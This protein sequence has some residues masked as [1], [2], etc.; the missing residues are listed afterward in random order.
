[1]AMLN[2]QRV[3]FPW[4]MK[5]NRTRLVVN[6]VQQ[7]VLVVFFSGERNIR[8]RFL[9]MLNNTH[10]IHGAAIYGNMDPINIPPLC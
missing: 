4:E 3:T 8:N 6:W 5:E 10:R 9:D 1:M 2:N 7:N